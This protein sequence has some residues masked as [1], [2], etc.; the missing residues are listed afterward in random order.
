[1]KIIVADDDRE[2]CESLRKWHLQFAK[3]DCTH[4]LEIFHGSSSLIDYLNALIANTNSW[5]NTNPCNN[6]VVLLDLDIDG[7]P[8]GGIDILKKIRGDLK[9]PGKNIPIVMYSN[10]NEESEINKCYEACA[11]SYVWKGY[12]DQKATFLKI[13][14]F[15]AH[16]AMYPKYNR[17]LMSNK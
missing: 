4:S 3:R 9:G 16:A 14:K 5:S 17:L 13:M 8:E 1:M 15:W 7:S 2:F 10:T 11:N 6:F 12:K